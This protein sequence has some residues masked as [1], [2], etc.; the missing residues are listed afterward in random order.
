MLA[1]AHSRSPCVIIRHIA[2]SVMQIANILLDGLLLSGR[3]QTGDL[4]AFGV[5]TVPVD[6]DRAIELFKAAAELGEWRSM[7]AGGNLLARGCPG[8]ASDTDK[9][10]ALYR[11]FLED[12]YD[13][14]GSSEVRVKLAR[15]L[16]RCGKGLPKRRQEAMDL[17][18]SEIAIKYN[19]DYKSL[20]FLKLASIYENGDKD[21]TKDV[22]LSISYYR[23]AIA[24][25]GYGRT[26]SSMRLAMLLEREGMDGEED[27]RRAASFGKEDI[28][29]LATALE[30]G[31]DELESDP[32]VAQQLRA[33]AQAL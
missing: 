6:L 33:R 9:A 27:L 29:A 14:E 32:S 15:L 4:Y 26:L 1:F 13:C 21:V 5:G 17:L 18:H 7:I 23:Q 28:L 19:D 22:Q 3:C 24:L 8:L 2:C 20:A 16:Y 12:C 30:N 10:E 25:D 11:Q 31:D